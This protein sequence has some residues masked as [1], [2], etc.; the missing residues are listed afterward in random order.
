MADIDVVKK[1]SSS[2]MWILVLVV[3][4]VLLVVLWSVMGSDEQATAPRGDLS[5]REAPVTMAQNATDRVAAI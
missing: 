3:A 1:G 2:W 5:H 4:V